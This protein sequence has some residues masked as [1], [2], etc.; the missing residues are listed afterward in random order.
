MTSTTTGEW[1]GSY[2]CAECGEKFRYERQG[3]IPDGYFQVAHD[4]SLNPPTWQGI[5]FTRPT[6]GERQQKQS[7]S[8]R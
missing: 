6:E 7:D 5:L 2:T 8:P 4:H 3:S 1:T